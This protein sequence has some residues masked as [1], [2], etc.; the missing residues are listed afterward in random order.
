MRTPLIV[1]ENCGYAIVLWVD[2]WATWVRG[3]G[4]S[5]PR[6]DECGDERWRKTGISGLLLPLPNCPF[7][8]ES[9]AIKFM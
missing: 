4:A 7:F 2:R 8:G 3:R 1:E 6:V 5:E 9:L